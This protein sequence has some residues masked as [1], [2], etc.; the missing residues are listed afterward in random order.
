MTRNL[1]FWY[2]VS[3]FL[4]ACGEENSTSQINPTQP[5]DHIQD[6]FS[7]ISPDKSGIQ[8]VNQIQGNE[9]VNH[10]TWDAMYYG[11]GVGIGDINN[12]GLPDIFL[13][14]NQVNDAIYLNKGNLQFEDITESSGISQHQG[15]SN[16]VSMADVNADGFLDIYVSRSSWKMDNEDPAY[17]ANALFINNGDLTFT[18]SATQYGLDNKGYSTQGVFTDYDHDGDLDMFLLNAPSN[19]LTQKVAYQNS[20]FPD[21]TADRLYKNE[22]GSFSDVSEVAGVKAFSFG[23]GVV[24]A[25][26]NHDGWVDIYVANDYERPDYLYIN[27]QDGTFK[28]ELDE[29]IK[30][31]PFTAMGCDAADINNDG[32]SDLVVL[33]MQSDDHVRS[34]TNMPT[35]DPERFWRFV[36]Q[37]Y[38]YQY[39]SNVLQLNHG[40]GYFSDIAQMAGIASTDWSWSVLLADLD[41]DSF[42]DMYVTNGINYDI[43]NNDFAQSFEQKMENGESIDLFELSNETPSTKLSNHMFH[44]QGDLTFSRVTSDWKMDQNSFSYGAAYGDLDLDGD[45]DLVVNNNNDPTFLYRNNQDSDNW[46]IVEVEG[47]AENPLGYGTKAVIFHDGTMQFQEL[48]VVKGY[49]SSCEPMMHFGIGNSTKVDSLVVIFSDGKSVR[50]YDVGAKKRLNILHR[51]AKKQKYNVY[52][53]QKPIFTEVTKDLNIT[54]VH[55]ENEFNDYDKEI[56]LPHQQSR[57]GPDIAVGDVNGDNLDDFFLCGAAGS[58]GTLMIQNSDGTFGA[59]ASSALQNDK[60]MEDVGAAFLDADADGDLDLIVSSGGYEHPEG[61]ENYKHRLYMNDGTG[62]LTSAGTR[63]PDVRSNG[64]CVSLADWDLDGDLDVFIGGRGAP[65][66]Y[67]YPETSFLLRQDAD[68]FVNITKEACV[69]CESLGMVTDAAWANVDEDPEPELVVVGEWM[70][71]SFLD[72]GA[73]GKVIISALCDNPED[74][75]GWWWSVEAADTNGDGQLDFVL[76]NMG[77]NNKY[78]TSTSRP[79]RIYAA[80]FDGNGNNDVVLSKP[81]KG[82]FVPV[83]GRQCSSEQLPFVGEKFADF[84]SFANA[85]I[86]EMLGSGIEDALFYE[87]REFRSGVLIVSGGTYVFEAFPN[88]AQIGPIMGTQC[89]DLNKDGIKDLVLAG[90]H[91]DTEVETTRHDGNNGVVFMGK[92]DGSYSFRDVLESGFY[93]PGN[94]KTLTIL[95]RHASGK[96]LWLAGVNNNAM[97]AILGPALNE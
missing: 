30:H 22:N 89:V 85:S 50:A 79:L 8:F 75:V 7:L 96:S 70:T 93:V 3:L 43:R 86:E 73:D 94:V 57:N 13:S 62:N 12:D 53:L 48:S 49:Q 45:L 74:M 72:F 39:M 24:A 41:H 54:L 11:G 80:D 51:E 4:F 88:I 68:Q 65:G 78:H 58:A 19:N 40:A 32:F 61:S 16:G 69:G 55:K 60:K 92:A 87:A 77:M 47:P 29:K 35:M 36:A 66:K 5:N 52:N 82:K 46:L 10:L 71:P 34:K 81:Y 2:V 97:V 83:R 56:L 91:F 31:T 21:F 38:N 76:G 59:K 14:G 27:Q 26:V 15:W 84:E 20:G 9:N 6:Q 1:L 28:N 63:W 67:P 95:P 33:D 64:S 25:D 37:G 42:K 90:N 17:R 23:L 44:N 18:E